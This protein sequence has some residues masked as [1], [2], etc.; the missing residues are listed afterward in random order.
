MVVSSLSICIKGGDKG[1]FKSGSCRGSCAIL[2]GFCWG[3]YS[4]LFGLVCSFPQI[5]GA[6]GSLFTELDCISLKGG[7]SLM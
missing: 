5:S 2:K 1:E 4:T 3:F 7:D 6:L